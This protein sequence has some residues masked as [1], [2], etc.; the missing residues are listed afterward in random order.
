MTT[1]LVTTITGA[2]LPRWL[3]PRDWPQRDGAPALA[4]IE[5]EGG[6]IGAVRSDRQ[7]GPD[8]RLPSG[9]SIDLQG[10]LVLPALVEAH[11]HLDKAYT[12]GRLGALAPGLLPAIAAM[13]E[14][15]ANWTDDDLLQ[16]AN[17]ALEAAWSAGVTHLRTHVDWWDA[18]APR[19]WQLFGELA[20]TWRTRMRLERVA[21][22]PLPLF[23]SAAAAR[24]IASQ[25][26][27][28]DD[29][30]LGAFIHTSNYARASL[31][32]LIDAAATA[33][34]ALDL[35]VDEELDAHACGLAHVAA[36]AAQ[37]TA[38]G[39]LRRI[40]CSH[41][42]AL[43]AQDDDAAFALLDRM[44]RV[45]LALIALPATNLLLQDARA[46]RTPRLRGLSLLHEARARG[47]PVLVG[48]DNV[49]DAFC[50]LG[51]FDP[52]DALRTGILAAQLD[53]PFD[54]WTDTICRA[55]WLGDAP[56]SQ[57]TL[58]GRRA[59][60]VVFDTAEVHTWPSLTARRVL[61]ASTDTILR[62]TI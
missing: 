56:D 14:D 34:L 40:V 4:T 29:A 2:R 17:R 13:H 16:R 1:S 22:V 3:L 50:P 15:R 57:P 54:K 26:A 9:A 6:V 21:L 47:I 39:G 37:C 48:S 28:S 52:V 25:I 61:R 42:C 31:D 62:I 23:Q 53:D 24:S 51:T 58:V 32:H 33:S 27:A 60:L 49:Q 18:G 41:A 35:H 11:A 55:D 7:S 45:P 20:Q 8:R 38:T 36:R 19:A 30:V 59:D 43:A 10:A 44:A 12:R 46:G 5:I